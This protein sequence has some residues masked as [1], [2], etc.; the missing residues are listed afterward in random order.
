MRVVRVL[1]VVPKTH[2]KK[3]LLLVLVEVQSIRK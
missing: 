3:D 1:Q 2:Q